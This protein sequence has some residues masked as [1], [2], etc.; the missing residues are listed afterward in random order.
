MKL[1]ARYK[2]LDLQNTLSECVFHSLIV[3]TS[4]NES[5]LLLCCVHSWMLRSLDVDLHQLHV[6]FFIGNA[7][8]GT[9]TYLNIVPH[10]LWEVP[11]EPRQPSLIAAAIIWTTS[12]TVPQWVIKSNSLVVSPLTSDSRFTIIILSNKHW[13]I[14]TWMYCTGAVVSPII[15]IVRESNCI[16]PEMLTRGAVRDRDPFNVCGVDVVRTFSKST[17]WIVLVASHLSAGLAVADAVSGEGDSITSCTWASTQLGWCVNLPE[18]GGAAGLRFSH[19]EVREPHPPSCDATVGGVHGTVDLL[20]VSGGALQ[21]VVS[22]VSRRV[23][24]EDLPT[25]LCWFVGRQSQ[26]AR[27]DWFF[28]DASSARARRRWFCWRQTRCRWFRWRWACC[29]WCCGW[30]PT[31]EGSHLQLEQCHNSAQ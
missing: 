7:F 14:P 26:S 25:G 13:G 20:A 9:Q 31:W 4:P 3:P 5:T 15:V 2:R 19:V 1:R 10:F 8:I 11:V 16:R 30:R 24:L 21:P 29:R 12:I 23:A 17:N 28:C 6:H 27:T 22:G 18:G